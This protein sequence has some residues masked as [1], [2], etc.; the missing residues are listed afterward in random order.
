MRW[1]LQQLLMF[2]SC[3]HLPI[4]Q[5]HSQGRR[6]LSLSDRAYQLL[7]VRQ[8]VLVRSVKFKRKL[9]VL[10]AQSCLTLGPHA[11]Q[12]A[13]LLEVHGI[14]QARVLEWVAIPFFGGSSQARNPGRVSCVA[15]RFFTNRATREAQM[16]SR[17]TVTKCVVPS[18]TNVTVFETVRQP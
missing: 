4:V 10:V 3:I 12:P 2:S 14:L 13:S 9:Q 5:S 1:H 11:L 6:S 7:T 17:V 15:G 8:T 16:K 18:A